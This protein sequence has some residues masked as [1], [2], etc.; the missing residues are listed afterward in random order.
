MGVA[1][2]ARDAAEA[3]PVGAPSSRARVLHAGLDCISRFGLT[4]TTVDDIAR[5]A[6]LSRATLYRLF[7]GGREEIV[8]EMVEEEVAGFFR[9]VAADMSGHEDLE[10]RLVAAMKSAAGQLASHSALG[11]ILANEPE[12]V[13]P[14]VSFSGFDRVLEAAAAFLGPYLA[15]ELEA[16][17]A[18]RVGEWVTRLLLSHLVCPPG[19]AEA[20]AWLPAR[21]SFRGAPGTPFTLHPQ[22][23]DE[24]RVRSLVRRFVL[25]GIEVLRRQSSGASSAAASPP[26]GRAASPVLGEIGLPVI[27]TSTTDGQN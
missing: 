2:A 15:D 10:D 25:P 24:Q 26:A 18:R 9:V 12:L 6:G 20:V 13:L 7:P 4:K 21:S 19:A 3:P 23:L 8:R 1:L 17:D 11:C 5:V 27:G 22:T 16:E 14:L